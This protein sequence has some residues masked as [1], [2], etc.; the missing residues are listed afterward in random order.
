MV[1]DR[2]GRKS[3]LALVYS[4][5]LFQSLAVWL[6]PA[7]K[8][9]VGGIGCIADSFWLIIAACALASFMGGWS[10]ALSTSFAVMAD[11]TEGERPRPPPL[12]AGCPA[13][14]I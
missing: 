12:S 8:I 14:D 10:V 3:T 9:C 5:V 7:G 13:P 4:G 6:I 1:A 2:F 11:V